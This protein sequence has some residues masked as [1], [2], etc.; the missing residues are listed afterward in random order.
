MESSANGVLLEFTLDKRSL[1]TMSASTEVLERPLVSQQLGK[2]TPAVGGQ[3]YEFFVTTGHPRR[4]DGASRATIRRVVMRNFFND[5]NAATDSTKPASELSSTSTIEAGTKLKGRFRLPKPGQVIGP[6]KPKGGPKRAEK[7]SSKQNG[8][9]KASEMGR[10]K[11]PTCL[12]LEEDSNCA[13]KDDNRALLS[14]VILLSVSPP[15]RRNPTAHS[16]DPFD[17]L[18]I[19]ATFKLDVLLPFCEW[20]HFRAPTP[21]CHPICV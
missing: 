13:G 6:E 15:P 21:C 5:K 2:A 1:A 9:A 3:E 19:P 14:P 4:V 17:V 16:F 12:V 8:G 20:S 10:K 11:S 7:E 18:P